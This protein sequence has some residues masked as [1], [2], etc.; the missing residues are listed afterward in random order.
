M[1][2][3]I[4]HTDPI[5]HMKRG[6]QILEKAKIYLS[7]N[8]VSLLEQAIILINHALTHTQ[9]EPSLSPLSSLSP[10]P[11]PSLKKKFATFTTSLNERLSRMK[12]ILAFKSPIGS[13][14]SQSG[15]INTLMSYVTAASYRELA[16]S[17]DDR[18]NNGFAI[19]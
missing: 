12:T 7:E 10:S 16:T 5:R 14:A 3:F 19:I 17:S 13:Q 11:L 2:R 15:L 18:T 8:E 9:L 1:D 6:V 4:S